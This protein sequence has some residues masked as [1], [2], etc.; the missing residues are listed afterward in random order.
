M[1]LND[2]NVYHH[3]ERRKLE[4]PGQEG[5]QGRSCLP[6]CLPSPQRIAVAVPA[7]AAKPVPSVIKCVPEEKICPPECLEPSLAQEQK[8]NLLLA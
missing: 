7:P 4:G 1:D 6:T 3:L 5:L 8:I 2:L